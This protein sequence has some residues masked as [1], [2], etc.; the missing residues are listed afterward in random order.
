MAMRTLGFAYKI[1]DDTE[2]ADCV[3][4]VAENDLSFLG[5]VAISDPIR[6]DVPAAV[7]KCQSAGIGVKIREIRRVRQPKSHGKSVY[8]N[9]KIRSVTVLRVL[10]L[11]T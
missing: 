11:Q 10:P 1:V 2:P 3:A 8:G 9:R 5:V 7:A 6:P 4:L